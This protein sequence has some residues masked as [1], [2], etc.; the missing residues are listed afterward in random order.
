MACSR[1]VES[2]SV[3]LSGIRIRPGQEDDAEEL[4]ALFHASVRQIAVHHDSVEPVRAW[5]PAP[6]DRSRFVA[7]I[8]DGRT[9]LVATSDD[10][11]LAYG[12]LEA[13]GHIDHLYARPDVAGT[14]VTGLIY[15]RL[16]QAAYDSGIERL[17]V[18]ASEPASRFFTKRG[19]RVVDRDDFEVAG[20]QIHNFR[21]EKLLRR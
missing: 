10:A 2:V 4:A 13:N 3:D 12:D 14:G 18:E 5:S 16:E 19:F 7:R 8:G 17:F 20:V 6:S 9:F 1:D 11:I 15:D 21:M